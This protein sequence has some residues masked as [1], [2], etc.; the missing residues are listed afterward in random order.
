M[1]FFHEINYYFNI[2]SIKN[3][4]YK[5]NRKQT[6]NLTHGVIYIT[7]RFCQELLHFALNRQTI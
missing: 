7:G 6:I 3:Y 1:F 4:F 5:I 2:F